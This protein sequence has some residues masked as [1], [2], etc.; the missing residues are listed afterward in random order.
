MRLRF[1]MRARFIVGALAATSLA[2]LVACSE[3]DFASD[4]NG[5]QKNKKDDDG[6]DDDDDQNGQDDDADDE[7]GGPGG[8]NV[9]GSTG[10]GSDA[11][12]DIGVDGSNGTIGGLN[13][14]VDSGAGTGVGI[15]TDEGG[16]NIP[17]VP[18]E[19]VGVNF[20][21]MGLQGDRDHND[22]VLCFTGAFKVDNTNVVSAKAQQVVGTTFSASGCDHTVR[23][24]IIHSD[25]TK[26]APISFDSSDQTPVTM[27]FRRGSKLEVYMTSRDGCNEGQ[28]KNMHNPVDCVVAPNVCNNS[29]G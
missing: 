21:D 20:E 15:A 6:D 2:S 9:V 23:V 25:G 29:G 22:A 17:G 26:E 10:T 11:T 7:G 16:I 3:S 18:V 14:G 27:N 1:A 5:M 24:E 28:E 12:G 8:P 19:R 13:N 4:A